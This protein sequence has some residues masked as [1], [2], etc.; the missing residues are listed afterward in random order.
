MK[1]RLGKM[2]A[3][4][5]AGIVTVSAAD[6]TIFAAK[7]PTLEYYVCPN[8]K[9]LKENENV[10][11]EMVKQGIL[12]F[13]AAANERES[14]QIILRGSGTHQISLALKGNLKGDNGYTIPGGN[15]EI[16]F[17]DYV[18]EE[19]KTNITD[20][21]VYP[22]ALIPI[23]IAAH[24]NF[25][26]NIIQFGKRTSYNY[27]Y[28]EKQ[29]TYESEKKNQGIWF[30][31][32]V[33]EGTP[34]GNYS[35]TLVCHSSETG[36]IHIP[37][38]VNVFD[39]ELPKKTESVEWFEVHATSYNDNNTKI[40]D[41][42]GI[43][44]ENA[45]LEYLDEMNKFLDQ[46][47]ITS[48]H[49][50]VRYNWVNADK[51][52]V[53][54]YIDG[55]YEFVLKNKAPYYDITV[56]YTTTE[57]PIKLESNT[58]FFTVLDTSLTTF[59]GYHINIPL[60]VNDQN[61]ETLEDL[62]NLNWTTASV[63]KKLLNHID[64]V[65]ANLNSPLRAQAEE[66]LGSN[67]EILDSKNDNESSENENLTETLKH[68][69]AKYLIKYGKESSVPTL[70]NY[71][72]DVR[73]IFRDVT[74]EWGPD[75][76]TSPY[77]RYL[78][79]PLSVISASDNEKFAGVNTLLKGI[80]DKSVEKDL[81]LLQYAFLKIPNIDEPAAWTLDAN[82]ETL[83]NARVFENCKKT[84][85]EYIDKKTANTAMK[86][87]LQNSLNNLMFLFT[88]AP[89][90]KAMS[91]VYPHNNTEVVYTAIQHQG[92]NQIYKMP[93]CTQL[94]KL[95]KLE[96]N[97]ITKCNVYKTKY[98]NQDAEI[99]IEDTFRNKYY[100]TLF[101]DF[102]KNNLV[103]A[104]DLDGTGGAL[105]NTPMW[106]YSCTSNRSASIA[107]FRLNQNR[108]EYTKNHDKIYMNPIAVKRANKW[109][110][111]EMG[112]IGEH[113]WAVDAGFKYPET[114]GEKGNEDLLV[115]PIKKYMENKGITR[116]ELL[117]RY[118]YYAKGH[119]F[120]TIRLE[121]EA[122]ANDD[123]DYL[124][125]AEQL[126][127]HSKLDSFMRMIIEPANVDY[128]N[129]KLT[130]STN[131][132]K[133]RE[134]LAKLIEDRSEFINRDAGKSI[135]AVKMTTALKNWHTNTKKLCFNVLNT[136]GP[137]SG[138]NG[139]TASFA[140]LDSEG[141]AV[142]ASMVINCDKKTITTY[143]AANKRWVSVSGASL[144]EIGHGWYQ[145]SLTLNKVPINKAVDPNGNHTLSSIS[146][147]SVQ[148]SFLID[149]SIYLK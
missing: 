112:I 123:Y 103:S 37:V 83:L 119:F 121:N 128:T 52:S 55:I 146:F 107:G 89:T 144:S 139:Q 35:S 143:D 99:E 147:N 36:T 92:L 9:I 22:D 105:G 25:N 79:S 124:C 137:Q 41:W 106:W 114:L 117:N 130:N 48:G 138:T 100:C 34:A 58:K 149:K 122:E 69:Y 14:G 19:P 57:A 113:F 62:I 38:Q 141:R 110:Q 65:A 71:Q 23:N 95:L 4:L 77:Y 2:L 11:S 51:N 1:T 118:Y 40:T 94:V 91:F 129:S 98:A 109:Q 27:K 16:F 104:Q 70:A 102:S 3:C 66:Y 76:V 111:Y 56:D 32:S 7:V 148:R 145:V 50:G 59:K 134:V 12:Q 90:T 49:S 5:F 86:A 54:A 88:T 72:K 133:A 43:T 120:S 31:V 132:Q 8:S 39:F 116:S 126:V 18:F 82:L 142:S 125:I 127:G 136:S 15:F 53:S 29:C 74:L 64:T 108:G 97:P 44:G 6:Y 85:K 61:V 60:K 101:T 42:T 73:A 24:P 67:K 20:A 28:N 81:D 87:S 115:Y 13:S 17:E 78:Y 47:K 84:I 30:T 21:G 46:R 140:L 93:N 68:F 80:V 75:H 45:N 26:G 33:P 63:K 10:D 96:Y 131:L 135:Y